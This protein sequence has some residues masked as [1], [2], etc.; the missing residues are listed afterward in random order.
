LIGRTDKS[1]EAESFL[2][3]TLLLACEVAEFEFESFM[4]NLKKEL[5][6][7]EFGV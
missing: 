2:S 1:C 6:E 5:E 7:M 4:D 3:K